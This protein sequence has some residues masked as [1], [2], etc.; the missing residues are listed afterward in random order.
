MTDPAQ[1]A[2]QVQHANEIGAAAGAGGALWLAAVIGA[3]AKVWTAVFGTR[4][5]RAEASAIAIDAATDVIEAQREDTRSVRGERDDCRAEVRTLRAEASQDRARIAA[6]E[7][8]LA[9]HATCGPRIAHLEREARL[10]SAMLAD[11]MRNASTPPHGLYTPDDVR[12]ALAAQEDT[13]P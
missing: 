5:E 12:A 8:G 1:T 3:I 10:S 6:L 13:G 4:K 9:E 11:L 7:A 2:Q